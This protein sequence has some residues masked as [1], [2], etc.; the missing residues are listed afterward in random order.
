MVCWTLVSI[1]LVNF[2][3][4]AFFF[5]HPGRTDPDYW[6]RLER[7]RTRTG[8]AAGNPFTVFILG[9]RLFLNPSTVREIRRP[10]QVSEPGP[11]PSA[12]STP[13][14]PTRPRRPPSRR[15]RRSRLQS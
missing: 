1:V 13:G 10:A 7:I 4:G 15:L 3:M 5:R 14:A 12:A 11:S 8:P 9:S 6:T 2:G